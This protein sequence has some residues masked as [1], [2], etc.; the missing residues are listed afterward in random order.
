MK[1]DRVRAILAFAI[2]FTFVIGNAVAWVAAPPTP[3]VLEL[4]ADR[5]NELLIIL[6]LVFSY[7][8]STRDNDKD[9]P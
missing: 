8:F 2:L 3:V 7:Y 4:L 6:A 1:K 9:P 5:S